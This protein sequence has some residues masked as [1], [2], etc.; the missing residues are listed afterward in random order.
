MGG[1]E[2]AMPDSMAEAAGREP[3]PQAQARRVYEQHQ[4]AGASLSGAALARQLGISERHGRGLLAE[5]RGE[6][7]AQP[8]A[9]ATAQRGTSR[10]GPCVGD[11]RGASAN[12]SGGSTLRT[13]AGAHAAGSDPGAGRPDRAAGSDLDRTAG[14]SRQSA[15]IR[16][17]PTQRAGASRR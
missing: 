4:A 1:H 3:D 11:Q 8:V 2:P 12:P 7:E 6:E 14:R 15:T 5:L 16:V 10:Q 9:T 17:D 13:R